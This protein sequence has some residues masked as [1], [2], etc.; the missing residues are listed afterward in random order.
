MAEVKNSFIKSKMNQ[1]LDDRLIPNGEYREAFNVSINK[2]IGENVGT[3]QTVLGNE[4]VVDFFNEINKPNLEV[5][6]VLPD[7]VNNIVYVFLTNNIID[8]YVPTGAVGNNQTYPNFQNTETSGGPITLDNAGTGYSTSNATGETLALTGSGQGMTVS[9]TETGGVIDNVNI[10]KFGSGYAVG[11]TI[12]IVGG[13]S[14]AVISVDTILPSW[15][16]VVSFD[17]QSLNVKTIAEG[18]WL[19]F[20]TLYPMTGVNILEDLLFFTDNRNQ[21][22]KVNVT[23]NT[24]YYTSE[25]QLSVAK[26]YPFESIQLYQP[27]ELTSAVVVSDTTSSAVNSSTTIPLTTGS[28]SILVSQ[29]VVGSEVGQNVFVTDVS[30]LPTSVEVNIPQTLTSGASLDFVSPETTMQDAASED[31]GPFAT[32]TV[33]SG[34][35]GT[36]SFDVSQS[37][38]LG[39]T[40]II[41]QTIFVET[42]SGSFTDLGVTVTNFTSGTGVFVITASAVITPSVVAGDVVK[43]AI[44]NPYYDS[45]FA[46]KA[47]A[48]FLKDKFVRFSYRFKFDDGE[49]SLIAPFTQPCFIPNQDGYFLTQQV[50]VEKSS[51]E[52]KTLASTEVS[53]MENKVNKILLNIPLPYSASTLNNALKISEIDVLY[54]ESDKVA[55]K[56][57]DTIPLV[58]NVS[59]TSEYYQYEYGSKA[60]YKTLPE[61]ENIRVFDKVPVKAQSQEIASNRVIYGNYKDKHTPPKFLDYILAATEKNQF[62]TSEYE[63]INKTSIVEYPNATLKQNRSYEVGVVLADRFGRQSTPIFSRT[64]LAGSPSFLSSTVF[65]DYKTKFDSPANLSSFDGNSLKI[66]FNKTINGSYLGSPGLYNGDPD[67]QDYNPTGWYSY[68]IVVKQTE[69]EYYNAYVP[70]AMAAYP[71]DSSKELGIT[72]HVVLINDN[73]NKIPRDLTEVGPAQREFRSSVKMFGRVTNYLLEPALTSLDT[74]VQF[75]PEKISDISTN[76]ATIKDLFDY[77]NFPTSTTTDYLFYNFEIDSAATDEVA[78]SSSLVARISTQKKF[79]AEVPSTGTYTDGPF[80]NV[81]EIEPVRSLLDI[82]WETSTSGTINDLNNAIN[83]GGGPNSFDR[84]IEWNWYLREDNDGS[85]NPVSFFKPVKLDG[86]QFTT[87]GDTTAEILEITDGAGNLSNINN[88]KYYDVDNPSNGIFNIQ[89]NGNGTFNITLNAPSGDVG[90]VYNLVDENQNPVVDPNQYNITLK[91]DHPLAEETIITQ[92]GSFCVLN[93]A[94]P[95]LQSNCSPLSPIGPSFKAISPIK[96]FR[97]ENGSSTDILDQLGLRYEITQVI[98]NTDT[99][100]PVDVTDLGYFTISDDLQTDGDIDGKL[101]FTEETV[102]PATYLVTVKVY[103]FEGVDPGVDGTCQLT[104]PFVDLQ[105]GEIQGDISVQYSNW[106]QNPIN[107]DYPDPNKGTGIISISG[108]DRDYRVKL[109]LNGESQPLE[110]DGAEA[111]LSIYPSAVGPIGTPDVVTKIAIPVHISGPTIPVYSANITKPQGDWYYE[112]TVVS[113]P[114]NQGDFFTNVTSTCTIEEV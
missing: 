56:V 63:S 109:E 89:D 19:N 95:T 99:L 67:S 68:K 3:L 32:A 77:K 2:S 104:V 64:D 60:P 14:D 73:I 114:Q 15:G 69:Q 82:Y 27:S 34:S 46:A 4:S 45:D 92:E 28:A 84:I 35:G 85:I 38:F 71:L 107:D 59:G 53:F 91:F 40:P 83:A 20:S 90:L 50:G 65:S 96:T 7:N 42:L 48:S 80:L 26:Y 70:T 106:A 88:V 5:I 111:T 6:G 87:P 43:F 17:I 93:N 18:T 78:D 75:Y 44:E 12:R 101:Y 54:K 66:Q 47:N 113:N 72:S 1:D 49:Y 94:L 100:N 16:A 21:P 110:S 61:S 112:I 39:S 76:I 74:N 13:N 102:R 11:D 108:D 37:S 36:N 23:Y 10:V 31:L 22:R 52:E 8:P 24:G 97:A 30:N 86:T 9:F 57:V 105:T 81:L 33:K 62:F 98:D 79:G 58:G 25:D 51:D 55:I 41:G 103:D 29:G